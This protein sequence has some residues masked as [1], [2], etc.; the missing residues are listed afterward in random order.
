MRETHERA[1]AAM[2]AEKQSLEERLMEA[3]AR[4]DSDVTNGANLSEQLDSAKAQLQ[5]ANSELTGLRDLAHSLRT[6][7]VSQ[8]E[9]STDIRDRK[10]LLTASFFSLAFTHFPSETGLATNSIFFC[11]LFVKNN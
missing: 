9:I 10:K 4:G 7:L 5:D 3:T 11:F 2:A 6:E 8:K 1:I